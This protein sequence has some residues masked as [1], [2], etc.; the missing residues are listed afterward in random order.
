MKHFSEPTRR[1]QAADVPHNNL[2]RSRAANENIIPTTTGAARAV[3]DVLPELD[4]KL[5]GIAMRV[6]VPDGSTV[7]LV[8]ELERPA[9]VETLNAAMREAASRPPLEHILEYT[10]EPLVSSDIIGNPHSAVFD[11]LSTRVLGGNL[12]KVIAWYDN[13]WAYASRVVDLIDRLAALGT[14]TAA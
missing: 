5:D 8:V 11:A 10:E 1:A 13:E 2:R 6:P 12:V 3:G 9:S 4:G 7:D 14:P